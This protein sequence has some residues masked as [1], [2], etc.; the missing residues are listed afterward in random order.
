MLIVTILGKTQKSTKKEI[1]INPHSTPCDEHYKHFGALHSRP[2]SLHRYRYKQITYTDVHMPKHMH[3]LYKNEIIFDM[4]FND[5]S[6]AS[7]N[8]SYFILLK[9]MQLFLVAVNTWLGLNSHWCH[10]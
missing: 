9:T 10:Q 7:N 1:G 8:I 2:F 3:I 5:L 6:L 4:R